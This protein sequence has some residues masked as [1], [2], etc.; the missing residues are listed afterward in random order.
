MPFHLFLQSDSAEGFILLAS[1]AG[2]GA[3]ISLALTSVISQVIEK[4]Y[5][6]RTSMSCS[7]NVCSSKSNFVSYLPIRLSIVELNFWLAALNGCIILV[8]RRNSQ[9]HSHPLGKEEQKANNLANVIDEGP[10]VPP[11]TLGPKPSSYLLVS[12][13]FLYWWTLG[14]PE[15]LE[16]RTGTDNYCENWGFVP[17][18]HSWL[19][20][21]CSLMIL[22]L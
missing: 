22:S 14:C 2:E 12:Y 4:R 6:Y 18:S 20:F 11:I 5:W 15:M 1:R 21:V 10:L 7:K 3:I 16:R 9:P 13:I 8:I 17:G 19:A